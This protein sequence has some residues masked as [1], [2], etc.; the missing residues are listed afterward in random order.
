MLKPLQECTQ[1]HSVVIGEH[2]M[3]WHISWANLSIIFMLTINKRTQNTFYS[4]HTL[5][6]IIITH[7]AHTNT[8]AVG[9]TGYGYGMAII[10][11]INGSLLPNG[12]GE[13][14]DD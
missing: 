13:G 11:I 5:S 6:C 7:T 14:K 9:P 8:L 3:F 10:I 12:P 4:K 1:F 2:T